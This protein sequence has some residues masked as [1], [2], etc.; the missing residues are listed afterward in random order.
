MEKGLITRDDLIYLG[1]YNRDLKAIKYTL[2][3]LMFINTITFG[4]IE[5]RLCFQYDKLLETWQ[6]AIGEPG[7]FDKN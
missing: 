6:K 2:K 4:L 1:N 3:G 7:Y 5:D